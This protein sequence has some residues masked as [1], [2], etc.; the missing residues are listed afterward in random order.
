MV[1]EFHEHGKLPSSF[2]SYFV[3]L[4]PKVKNPHNLSEFRPIS[5]LGSRYKIISK[6]LAKIF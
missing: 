1:N 6:L 5:L 2:S 4:I 3:A